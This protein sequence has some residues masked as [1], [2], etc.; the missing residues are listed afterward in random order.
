LP[1]ETK[2]PFWRKTMES[3]ISSMY[4]PQLKKKKDYSTSKETA[5]EK[6]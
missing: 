2:I 6:N 4:H 3:R 5:Q 1:A